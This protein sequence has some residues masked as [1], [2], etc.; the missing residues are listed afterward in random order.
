MYNAMVSLVRFENK[1]IFFC[2][3]KMLYPTATVA[4]L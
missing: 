3:V 4:A 1:N 2:F